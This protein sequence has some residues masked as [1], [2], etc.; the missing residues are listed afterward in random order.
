MKCL[1]CCWT[2]WTKGGVG[3]PVCGLPAAG[4]FA[5]GAPVDVS[6][7]HAELW[8]RYCDDKMA[9][10]C[11]CRSPTQFVN[12]SRYAPHYVARQHG[13]QQQLDNIWIPLLC[14][15][16]FD[17]SLLSSYK[18]F[19]LNST[20]LM[21]FLPLQT[22]LFG[23]RF[24]PLGLVFSHLCCFLVNHNTHLNQLVR[25]VCNTTAIRYK[26]HAWLCASETDSLSK[27]WSRNYR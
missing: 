25:S 27:T 4:V 19:L 23:L 18:A 15:P 5:R 6:V 2:G 1:V 8:W 11:L 16:V 17:V 22:F 14:V 24:I 20:P 9:V 13:L 10:Y 7:L 26:P 21:I 3:G 12:Y